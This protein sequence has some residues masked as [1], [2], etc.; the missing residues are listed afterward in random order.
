MLRGVGRHTV[1]P[2]DCRP[3]AQA[4]FC[5]APTTRRKIRCSNSP[6][7]KASKSGNEQLAS[8]FN[9]FL[10]F[11]KGRFSPKMFRWI[12]FRVLYYKLLSPY[13]FI[14]NKI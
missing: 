2:L 3:P 1:G 12:C 5:R 6:G 9:S 7:S 8:L 10:S 11:F 4:R 13:L 14:K